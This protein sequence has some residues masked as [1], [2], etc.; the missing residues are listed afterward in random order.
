M[1]DLGYMLELA[2]AAFLAHRVWELIRRAR[3]R[4]RNNNVIRFV[5]RR[6]WSRL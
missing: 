6:K 3:A 1:I 5:N 2:V 4:S